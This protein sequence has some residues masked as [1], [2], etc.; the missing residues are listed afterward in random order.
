MPGWNGLERRKNPC[1]TIVRDWRRALQAEWDADRRRR[2]THR[3][4]ATTGPDATGL[5]DSIQSLPPS[6][7]GCAPHQPEDPTGR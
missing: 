2:E 7:H 1:S 5:L 6:T 4:D 3:H